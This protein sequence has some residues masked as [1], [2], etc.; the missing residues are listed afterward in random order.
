MRLKTV[1]TA[2]GTVA[3]AAIGGVTIALLRFDANEYRGFVAEQLR[4]VTGREVQLRGPASL[5]LGLRPAVTADDVVIGNVAGGSR[6]E[7]L[8]IRRLEGEVELLP[9]IFSRQV[10][11]QRLQIIGADV[12]LETDAQ[13]RGNWQ[14]GQSAPAAAAQPAAAQPAGPRNLPEIGDFLVRDSTVVYF[15]RAANQRITLALARARIRDAAGDTPIRLEAE[16]RLQELPFDLQGRLGSLAALAANA[17]PW[18]V[19]LNLRSGEAGSVRVAGAIA[20]PLGVPHPDVT[21]IIETQEIAR[22]AALV[23]RQSSELGPFR[24]EAKVTGAANRVMALNNIRVDFGRREGIAGRI[25]G[26][27]TDGMGM[28]GAD[29]TLALEVREIA[30]LSGLRLPGLAEPIPRLP[31]SGRLSLE[32]RVL[33]GQRGAS[34]QQLRLRFGRVDRV[35]A[36]I[37]GGV[38]ELMGPRGLDLRVRIE[39]P[40]L[41][42]INDLRMPGMPTLN[43]P[44]LGAF[45]ISTR[46]GDNF[47]LRD[48]QVDLGSDERLRLMANGAIQNPLQRRGVNLTVQMRTADVA[49]AARQIGASAPFGGPLAFQ[50]RISDVS[51]ARYRVQGLRLTALGTETTGDVTVGIGARPFLGGELAVGRLDLAAVGG[52]APSSGGQAQGQD[53]SRASGRVFS[54]APLPLAGLNAADA[55]LRLRIAQLIGM[56]PPLRGVDTSIILRNGELNVRSFSAEA[57]GGRL[58]GTLAANAQNGAV[59]GRIDLRG[60]DAGVLLR[61]MNLTG[62]I[63]GG[64]LDA[65]TEFRGAGRS[66]RGIVAGMSG[67]QRIVMRE[68]SFNSRM[69]SLLSAD[70]VTWTQGLLGDRG[71]T[72]MQCF[73]SHFDIREGTA[74]SRVTLFHAAAGS[75]LVAGAIDLGSEQLALTLRPKPSESALLRIAPMVRIGGT[76]ASPRVGFDPISGVG[77]AVGA[78]GDVVQRITESGGDARNV[79]EGIVRDAIGARRNQP[80]ARPP[81]PAPVDPCALALN[82]ANG[83]AQ[84]AALERALFQSNAPIA[85]PPAPQGSAQP[86]QPAQP[87]EQPNLRERVREGGR[88]LLRDLG[89]GILGR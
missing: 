33:E 24:A 73:I 63:N 87:Q 22:L 77:A 4:S 81:A 23:G 3:L 62:E 47:A 83:Q 48:L 35:N 75:A 42:A 53:A 79:V 11:I 14:L 39:G 43:L 15:D 66:I 27:I 28:R 9:L 7:M 21:V 19:E 5:S 41:A 64:R 78:A 46:V 6:P 88:E 30:S 56:G 72:R 38:A 16:G 20:D 18:P 59:N 51:D 85:A 13:G 12:L 31:E 69:M 17:A 1:L 52:R 65:L 8:R 37:E 49:M 70:L 71:W 32:A 2:I 26:S 45:R 40:E 61:E 57:A 29:L 10:R 89:R 36:V 74:A 86:Q 84:H 55:E 44:A 54:D 67:V 82:V 50:G 76:L 25:T 60:A 58:A 68:G 80:Q 34:L